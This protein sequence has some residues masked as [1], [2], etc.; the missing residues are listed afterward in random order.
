MHDRVPLLRGA[1][2]PISGYSKLNEFE[3]LLQSSNWSEG[4]QGL[5][6]SA[7]CSAPT[8]SAAGWSLSHRKSADTYDLG[9][10][11]LK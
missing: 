4:L 10:D 8:T 11:D 7:S 3:R 2:P 6:S 1:C 5:S 9:V